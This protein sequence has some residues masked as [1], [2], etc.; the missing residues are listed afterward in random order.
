MTESGVPRTRNTSPTLVPAVVHALR[1]S[2]GTRAR[3]ILL[4]VTL[5]LGLLA[6]AGLAL[7]GPTGDRTL[8]KLSDLVQSLMSVIVPAFGILLA[9][10]L[11]RAAGTARLA[12]TLLAATL[13]A[14]AIGLFGL[15]VCVAALAMTTS[16][17]PE[18]WRHAGTI[19]AGSVLVQ[20]VAQL[21]GT[22]LGLLMRRPALA[23]A[24]SI[25]L[26]LGLWILLG[27]VDV[28]RPA[29]ALTPYSTVRHL[30]SG[31]MSALNWVQWLAVLLIWGVGL[32]ALGAARLRRG[33]H[34]RRPAPTP[35][36]QSPSLSQ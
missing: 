35:G 25:V 21:V 19:A 2:V 9:R 36:E 11:K 3:R 17:A 10:D 7:A 32:N 22:G 28:L 8:G 14:A 13:L 29:Q 30:L 6:A 23:F 24:A 1:R 34:D 5:L 26:P 20:V 12:P 4:A 27:A 18:P 33:S 15:V 16:T 31:E